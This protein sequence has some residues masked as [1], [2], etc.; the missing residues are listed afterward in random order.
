MHM[1]SYGWRRLDTPG[2]ELATWRPR[3][4]GA[5]LQGRVLVVESGSH[6]SVDYRIEVD[7]RWVTRLVDV[8]VM[9]DAH[10]AALRLE[11]DGDGGWQ[12]D[13]RPDPALQGCL[14]VDLQ[15]TPLTNALPVNRL[16]LD[17]DGA[18]ADIRAAWVRFPGLSVD[19]APQ[20]YQHLAGTTYRYTSLDSGFTAQV[21][22]DEDGFPIIYEG[23][24][25]RA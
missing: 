18:A 5:L 9:A 12:R 6:L 24:W 21:E 8:D 14:D 1:R 25:Q 15:V 13:G 10:R 4:D 19:A 20:R 7:A 22:M 11:H 2:L 16:R 23:L 3:A 17:D